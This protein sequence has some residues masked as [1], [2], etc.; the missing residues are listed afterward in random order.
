MRVRRALGAAWFW[1]VFAVGLVFLLLTKSRTSCAVLAAALAVQWW[2]N[3][4][5]RARALA[6][7]TAGFLICAAALAGTMFGAGLDDKVFDVAMLGRQEGSEALTGRVPIWTD[8][9]GYVRARPLQGYGYESFWSTDRIETISDDMQWTLREAHNAYLDALLSIGLIGVTAGLAAVA[10]GL[11]RAAA[12]YRDAADPGL[13]FI[14]C[15]LVFGIV[16]ACLESSMAG[17]GF[18]TFI[19]GS[20][21]MQLLALP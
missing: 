2:L 16:N 15:V 20:G 19:A 4:G 13:A 17:P 3:A 14:F 11:R 18:T 1:A 9:L 12:A 8:L 21:M 10:I 5:A 6:A 7:V